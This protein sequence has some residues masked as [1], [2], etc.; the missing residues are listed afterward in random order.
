MM[1]Q[2]RQNQS[3]DGRSFSLMNRQEGSGQGR[4]TT[5]SN[6]EVKSQRISFLGRTE[7]PRQFQAEGSICAKN[8]KVSSNMS[9]SRNC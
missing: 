6:A 3:G 8:I 1:I 4:F 7:G 5:R 2:C 9:H